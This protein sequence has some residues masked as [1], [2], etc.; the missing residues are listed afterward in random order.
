MFPICNDTGEVIAFS[1]RV[2][3]ADAKAAKYVNSPE[4]ILFTKGSVL[5]GLDR[6]KR[7]LIE[8]NSAV[9]CEG[10]LDLITAFEAGVQN[11]IAPQ[12]TAFTEKQ[13]HILKR[14]VEE[15]VLCFDADTAG[16]KA[17]ERSLGILLGES[18][19]VRVVEMPPGE[20]PDSLIRGQGVEAFRERIN[21]AK[22]FFD[23]QL[24]RLAARPDFASPRVRADAARRLAA[25]V[26]LIK[27][28][29]LR[30]AM[31]RNV[32]ARLELSTS[33]FARLVR[34]PAPAPAA[35]RG[36]ETEARVEPLRLDKWLHVLLHSV[37]HD[38][39]ARAWILNA[40]WKELL[41]R[42]P[43]STLVS[44][45]LEAN[46]QTENPAA[47]NAFLATLEAPESAALCNLLDERPL[48][49]ALTTAQAC[50]NEVARRQI[51]RRMESLQIQLRNPNLSPEEVA[52]LVT[53]IT[54]TLPSAF[55]KYRASPCHRCNE[56]VKG[57]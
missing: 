15:V 16:Q 28:Q 55:R 43:D 41:A 18:L 8:K 51:R 45:V 47:F 25:W 32:S 4:T 5:F 40:P 39:E 7:A 50:W 34:Q 44:K 42:E 26:G 1:G 52:R 2:L 3:Q 6:S 19:A 22:D 27:D 30:E 24:A 14:Y 20:D 23:F 35:R 56:T 37:L 11:V 31:I 29:I 13:A 48:P 10:Q 54:V 17:A 9:V 12:G 33:E 57:A 53:E 36:E 46:P 38:P 49:N 21:A